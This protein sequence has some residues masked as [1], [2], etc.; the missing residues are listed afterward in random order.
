M[1]FDFT[2]FGEGVLRLSVPAGQRIETAKSFDVDVSGTEANVASALARL[3]WRSGWVSALPDTPPGQRVKN[4]FHAHGVDLS[5]VIWREEGRVSTY[6]VEYAKPPRPIMIYYDRKDSCLTQLT[7]D[8]IDWNYLLDTRHLHLSGLTVPLSDGTQEIISLA[9]AK[10]R[11]KGI[12]TSFD[13]NYRHLL[14]SADEAR[15][16]LTPLMQDVDVLFLAKRDAAHIF[17]FDSDVS[18]VIDRLSQMTGARNIVMSLSSDGVAGWDGS[19]IQQ[20]KARDVD[21]IDRIGAGDAMISGVLHGWFGGS[22]VKGLHYGAMMAALAMSQNSEAVIT[23]KAELER[24]LAADS[25]DI[26]R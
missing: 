8:D 1:R 19:S 6:Y 20:V 26:F 16:R 25:I 10:A 18:D 11:E 4:N 13:V 14:W 17:G 15:E 9:L 22:L 3:G 7:P 2:T 5:A 23:N 21:I 24:L 12:T